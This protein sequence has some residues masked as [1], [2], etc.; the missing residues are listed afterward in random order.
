M[1][2]SGLCC[3]PLHRSLSLEFL[4]KPRP[5][6]SGVTICFCRGPKRP[7]MQHRLTD[8]PC[9]EKDWMTV[10]PFC[11]LR[12]S[13]VH[14][15]WDCFY[16][17]W[18]DTEGFPLIRRVMWLL[19]QSNTT[20]LLYHSVDGAN[21]KPHYSKS[22]LS[23]ATCNSIFYSLCIMRQHCSLNLN[24]ALVSLMFAGQVYRKEEVV[25]PNSCRITTLFSLVVTTLKVL[26]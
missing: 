13:L 9:S 18:A 14:S 8:S 5:S 26:Q 3:F 17:T 20:K 21:L 25:I 10:F 23:A 1:V 11:V 16:W 15:H 4:G 12:G 24:V 2:L 19:Q 22:K 6:S 7:L